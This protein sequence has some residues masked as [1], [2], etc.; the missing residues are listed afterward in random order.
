[1]FSARI[2]DEA[3]AVAV[4]VA[5]DVPVAVGVIPDL[6]RPVDLG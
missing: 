4:V 2:L 3:V 5:A 6:A 1:L